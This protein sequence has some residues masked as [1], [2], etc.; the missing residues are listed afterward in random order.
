MQLFSFATQQRSNSL[1]I[2]TA[3]TALPTP[4]SNNRRYSTSSDVQ[5]EAQFRESNGSYYQRMRERNNEASKRCRLKRRMKAEGLESQANQLGMSNKCVIS[6]R[7][8]C[9]LLLHFMS[10][11]L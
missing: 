6:M 11:F 10:Y 1:S 5:G 9:R 7:Y 2:S 4:R 8:L 3:S